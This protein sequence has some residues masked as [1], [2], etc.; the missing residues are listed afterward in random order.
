MNA[1]Q[2]TFAQAKAIK[3]TIG[4]ELFKLE[5]D[6]TDAE[7]ESYTL[8]SR[9]YQS[10]MN[11]MIEWALGAIKKLMPSQYPQIAHLNEATRKNITQREKLAA[12]CFKFSGK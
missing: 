9:A 8:A 11:D 2:K 6:W 4:A 12:V 1:T 10:A 7:A 3:E 5:R